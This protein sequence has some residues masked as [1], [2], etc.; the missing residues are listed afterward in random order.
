MSEIPT[1]Y[2]PKRKQPDMVRIAKF[3]NG[4]LHRDL[5]LDIDFPKKFQK[6]YAELSAGD[7][8]EFFEVVFHDLF[9]DAAMQAAGF[10]GRELKVVELN[11]IKRRIVNFLKQ[12]GFEYKGN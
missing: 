8:N 5:L 10:V 6:D 12:S 4:F 2:S 9:G 3:L 1:P 11:L 7:K